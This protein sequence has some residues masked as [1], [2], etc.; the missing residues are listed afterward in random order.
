MHPSHSETGHETRDVPIRPIVL[1]GII[2]AVVTAIVIAVSVG[3]FKYFAQP[4]EAVAP[5]PF[6]SN[7]PLSPGPRVEEHPSLELEQLRLKEDRTLTTYGW[8]DKQKGEVRIPIDRAIDLQLERG[9]PTRKET[10]KK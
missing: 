3:V 1:S 7:P 8:A 9:F 6:T 5:N 2:L 4:G 10:A